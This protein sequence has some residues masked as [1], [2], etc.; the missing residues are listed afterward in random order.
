MGGGAAGVDGGDDTVNAKSYEADA[1]R[2]VD[3]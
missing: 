1:D 3:P 2:E